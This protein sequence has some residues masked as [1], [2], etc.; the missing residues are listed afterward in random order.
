MK[1]LRSVI[2]I[3]IV[4]LG[5]LVYGAHWAYVHFS[6]VPRAQLLERIEKAEQGI[7]HRTRELEMMQQTIARN[8][9]YYA[10]SLP[11]TAGAAQSQY[12]F[13]LL[14]VLKVCEWD[15]PSVE[16]ANP[17]SDRTWRH[18]RYRFQVRGRASL[19]QASRFLYEFYWAAF[20][21]RIVTMTITP[22]ENSELVDVSLTIDAIALR[23]MTPAD[24]YPL[25]DRLP[26]GYIR[27][28]SSENFEDYRLIAERNLLRHARGGVDKADHTYLTMIQSVDDVPLVWLSDR[29]TD[30]V[31][32]LKIGERVDI[33]S[34]RGTLLEVEGRDVVFERGGMFW[35]LSVGECLNAA[36]ALPPEVRPPPKK[37][38]E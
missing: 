29:T 33:G 13:W 30:S 4:L 14:E 6:R 1:N 38:E 22:V 25:A 36:Y 34:F 31:V 2:T 37:K 26:Q 21:H 32:K 7:A 12:R 9:A 18:Y 27:R 24:P 8:Q 3:L 5:G 15:Y 17:T 28:L 35:L 19:D 10:R 11:R 20:L 23:P 16:A